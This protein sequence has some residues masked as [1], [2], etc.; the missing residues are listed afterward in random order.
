VRRDRP[1]TEGLAAQ[2]A[3]NPPTLLARVEQVPLEAAAAERTRSATQ[4]FQDTRWRR[5][6]RM[7]FGLGS[8][9]GFLAGNANATWGVA[10]GFPVINDMGLFLAVLAVAVA[11]VVE[12]SAKLLPLL[13]LRAEEG[14]VYDPH[15]WLILGALSGLG[16]TLLEALT[17]G[18]TIAPLSPGLA[19]YNVLFRLLFPLHAITASVSGY[20]YGRYR[21]TR[22]ASVLLLGLG[23]A[24]AMH[25]TWNLWQVL[26][27]TGVSP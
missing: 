13:L 11:P 19:G 12:E 21:A 26:G 24:M 4:A 3:T 10:F 1:R 18:L 14:A 23:A 15:G 25:M 8:L 20:A 2:N 7:A 5:H 27:G 17:Y 16:F 22:K 6:K 9:A